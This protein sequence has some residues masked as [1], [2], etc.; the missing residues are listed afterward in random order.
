MFLFFF[1]YLQMELFGDDKK[2]E[3]KSLEEWEECRNFTAKTVNYEQSRE[4]NGCSSLLH[5][6]GH[7]VRHKDK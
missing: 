3:R 2:K 6:N 1:G 5:S 7:I 4:N